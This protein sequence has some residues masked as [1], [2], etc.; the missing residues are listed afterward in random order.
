MA[1]FRRARDHG[2][3]LSV[4][5]EAAAANLDAVEDELLGLVALVG[6][7]AVGA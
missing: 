2:H 3:D 5:V 7:M 4:F 1:V 6:A